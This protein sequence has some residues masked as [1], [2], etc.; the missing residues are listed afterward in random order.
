MIAAA[1]LLA[2]AAPQTAVDAERAF[3]AQA[4]TEGQ[5]TAFRAWAAPEGI[6]F[7]G[8]PKNAHDMLKGWKDPPVPVMWWPGRSWVSCD[9]GLAVNTGPWLRRGGTAQGTFTTVWRRL[10]DGS[11][12]WLSDNGRDT[13]RPVAAGDEPKVVKAACTRPATF[14]AGAAVPADDVMVQWEG[15]APVTGPATLHGTAAGETLAEG[16]SADGSLHWRYAKLPQL[17]DG[18]FGL[19][20]WQWDGRAHRLVLSEVSGLAKR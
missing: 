17:E 14:N 20:V 9:G 8:G 12:K 5:W 13:P 18:A 2:A 10:P 16:A 4:Q 19:D 7:D 11:W 6:M 3:A 15:R 1:V